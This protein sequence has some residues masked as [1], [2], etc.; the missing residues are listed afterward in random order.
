VNAVSEKKRDHIPY[1]SCKLTHVLK[2]ALGGNC[3]TVLIANIWGDAAQ[4]DETLSTC[5]FA[6]RMARVSA[7]V[8]S[9]VLQES[10]A[11]VRQLER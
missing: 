11:R 3:N 9:N 6:A 7:E 2:D 1:R 10:S 4:I 5:R 8:T